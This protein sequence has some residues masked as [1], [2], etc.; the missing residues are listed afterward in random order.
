M[1]ELAAEP[2]TMLRLVIEVRHQVGE[3]SDASIRHQK[4]RSVPV[5]IAHLDEPG[6]F[7]PAIRRRG[8][9]IEP[10][11]SVMNLQFAALASRMLQISSKA[12]ISKLRVTGYTGSIVVSHQS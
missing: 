3:I 9:R 12:G 6:L 8:P 2:F 10:R 7:R 11:R 5:N 4:E 1:I